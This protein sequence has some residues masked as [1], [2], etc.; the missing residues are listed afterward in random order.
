MNIDMNDGNELQENARDEA[1]PEFREPTRS[2]A[3]DEDVERAVQEAKDPP[4]DD[5]Q[6]PEL[7]L[8]RE[9]TSCVDV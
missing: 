4:A 3:E 9:A 8:A 5:E 1:S 7:E 2:F 6:G